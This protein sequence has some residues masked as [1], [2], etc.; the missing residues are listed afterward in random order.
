MESIGNSYIAGIGAYLPPT[1]VSSDELM[2]EVR[3]SRFGIPEDYMSRHVGISE[4]RVAD[5]ATQ[6]SDL[7]TLASES[8]LCDAGVMADEIDLIIYTSI[9]RD[10]DEPST[11]HF[12]QS[13]LG[14]MNATCMDVSNACLGF[15]TGLSIADAYISKGSATTVLV[16]AG[17]CQS[18]TVD[19]ATAIL[20]KLSDK[21]QFKRMFG[22]L[23]VGDAGGAMVIRP[24]TLADSGWKWLKFA[25]NGVHAD[26]CYFK[27][28][29]NGPEG[30]MQMAEIS[31]EMV[32][33]HADHIEH[34][35][36]T[37][38]WPPSTIA[39]LYCHQVGR[40]P[41]DLLRNVA[42]VNREQAPV[43]YEKF[44]NLTSATIPV[45]MYLNRPE[46]GERLLFLGAG[47]GLTICQGAMTF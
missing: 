3:C 40:K 11:A 46:R 5:P 32:R 13:R 8:A 20:R 47:S 7:A 43:T 19:A 2:A 36:K 34:T 17:E 23:T 16:C 4:R 41:Y 33:M 42:Q 44:G 24:S 22:V 28:S 37:I 21:E 39:K 1:R 45:G 9:T 31:R 27:R 6:P 30:A 15:M 18:H 35:Y 10:C 25:S 12:V 14:A 29:A 38:G 26:L